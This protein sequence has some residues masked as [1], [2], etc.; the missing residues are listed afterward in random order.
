MTWSGWCNSMYNA[1]G[2]T[3]SGWVRNST[4]SGIS[5][6]LSIHAPMLS[7]EHDEKLNSKNDITQDMLCDWWSTNMQGNELVYSANYS[8]DY[9]TSEMWYTPTLEEIRTEIEY[10]W[11][12][13]HG[14]IR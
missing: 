4:M 9:C 2:M 13:I 1:C 6:Y 8:Y 11:C 12:P 3:A 10:A 7:F 5:N 14:P